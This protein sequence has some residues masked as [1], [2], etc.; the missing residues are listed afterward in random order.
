[1]RIITSE[2]LSIVSTNVVENE[3]TA[4]A[5]GTTY[6]S[7]AKAVRN[8]RVYESIVSGN[9]GNDPAT[10]P[11]S[12]SDLGATNAYKMFDEFVNTSTINTT[13]SVILNANFASAI[14]LFGLFGNTARFVLTH[15]TL[16]VVF[17][18]TVE[19]SRSGATGSQT[20]SSW[21]EYFFGETV[22]ISQLFLQIPAYST[23]TLTITI[24][25]DGGLPAQCSCVV[26]GKLKELGA[27]QFGL[28]L[29]MED[30]SRKTT[31]D[32]GRTYLA[33]GAYALTASCD[34]E[35]DPPK[36][37]SVIRSLQSI[38]ATPVV[39]LCENDDP[40]HESTMIYGY[41]DRFDMILQNPA[42]YKY[43]LI[44]KGLI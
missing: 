11:A 26:L 17:D 18:Q 19:L 13:I 27:T 22:R 9:V 2:P 16:G 25:G 41:C 42:K 36:L 38:R 3:A 44:I 4:W 35:I 31:D 23:T 43:S 15:Q 5:A 34:L 39:W 7:G 29:S 10:S 28:Q 37:D 12:W 6:A 24:T 8:H 1:M 33:Q 21:S 30:Y 14:A 40:M 20:S 32:Y